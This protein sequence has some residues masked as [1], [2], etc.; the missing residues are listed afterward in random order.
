MNKVTHVD[1]KGVRYLVE[2]TLWSPPRKPRQR[3]EPE[4]Y[5]VDKSLTVVSAFVNEGKL[6]RFNSAQLL[7]T[8]SFRELVAESFG[9]PIHEGRTY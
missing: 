3:K 4:V 1:Y 7:K 5:L 6:V 9:H 8:Q 2:A